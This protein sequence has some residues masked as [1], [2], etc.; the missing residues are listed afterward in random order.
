[1]NLEMDFVWK[2]NLCDFSDMIF[3]RNSN[4]TKSELQKA[5]F[6]VMMEE[7]RLWLLRTLI[8]LK[9]VQA[10][11]WPTMKSAMRAKSRDT[12]ATLTIY[13]RKKICAGREIKT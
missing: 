13:R 1:M 12:V 3:C 10:L 7:T 2:N 9:I 6:E 5:L 11:D 8:S 4:N